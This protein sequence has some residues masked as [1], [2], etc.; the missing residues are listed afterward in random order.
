M[1]TYSKSPQDW[2][3]AYMT[4]K[5]E[6]YGGVKE[7]QIPPDMLWVPDVILYNK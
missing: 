2:N 5:P 1:L 4:W 7:I 6:D 3:S